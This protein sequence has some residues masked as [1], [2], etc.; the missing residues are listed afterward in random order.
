M[1]NSVLAEYPEGHDHVLVRLAAASSDLSFGKALGIANTTPVAYSLVDPK[2]LIFFPQD[3]NNDVEVTNELYEYCVSN[4]L[5]VSD[6]V[7]PLELEQW[8]G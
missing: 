3:G 7:V 2:H 4:E 1:L 6:D 8:A 5:V